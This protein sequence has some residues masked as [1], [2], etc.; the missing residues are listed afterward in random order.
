MPEEKLRKL[1]GKPIKEFSCNKKG[2]PDKILLYGTICKNSSIFPKG[3]P[4]A[5]YITDGKVSRKED[6][7][8]GITI[9]YDG[10][11]TLPKIV[12]PQNN[13]KFSHFPRSVGFQWYPSSGDYPM[14][15]EIEVD[16]LHPDG[17]YYTTKGLVDI[18]Y[19]AYMHGGMNDGRWRVRAINQRGKSEWTKYF[20][21]S[22]NK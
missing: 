14:T 4:F 16:I 22:F 18:P 1:L 6:P 3:F 5:I 13:T 15:Y 21:F 20:T 19:F 12:F 9:S 2:F 17:S 11:P 10:K 7:F 8:G